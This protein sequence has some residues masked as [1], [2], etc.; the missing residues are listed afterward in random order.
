MSSSYD[1]LLGLAL[2]HERNMRQPHAVIGWSGVLVRAANK[3][4]LIEQ[5]CIREVMTGVEVTRVIDHRDYLVGLLGYEGAIIPLIEL[6][7]LMHADNHS[8]GLTDRS[9]LV[10]S[11]QNKDFGLLVDKVLGSRD[12]WSDD[13][14]ADFDQSQAVNMNI[15]FTHKGQPIEV[16]NIEKLVEMV[17]FRKELASA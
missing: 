3:Q 10:I 2:L 16:F 8:L 15:S 1:L 4:I 7:T 14:L 17:G 5:D 12:Y 13:D 9:L 11:W 6:R